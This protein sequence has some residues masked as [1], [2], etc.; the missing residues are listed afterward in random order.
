[1]KLLKC[2]LL[3]YQDCHSADLTRYVEVKTALKASTM[4]HAR[5]LSTQQ[6]SQEEGESEVA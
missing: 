4:A 1:M 3:I 2:I 6:S 5:N